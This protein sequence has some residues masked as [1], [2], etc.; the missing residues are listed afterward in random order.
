M[1]GI[2]AAEE[3]TPE[4]L[5]AM[6]GGEL[7]KGEAGYFS[8]VRNTKRSSA[9]LKEAIVGNNLDISL[10]ILAAQQR[11][12]C[13]WKEYDA[14][15]VSSSEPPGSQ[16]KVVGRLADQC[17]DA[18]VQLGTFL[19]SSHAPDEY[20]ARLPPLQELLRDY[21]VDADVAFFLHRPVLAQKINAKVEY[22]RKLSD[23]KSD[24]IEKSIERYTQASQE[25][26]EP[27]VQSVTPILP[28][29]VWEDISPEF[30]VTFW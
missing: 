17:Q 8:Q 19:A 26:L 4:Q 27:I 16:L 22:L 24:S 29:K 2:E 20:A 18:L 9:R 10:C 13:V 3:M 5:E 15:S 21:H 6:A 12:C 7:L 14:D 23:S 25:A 28:N 1:A 30:Y 11:H